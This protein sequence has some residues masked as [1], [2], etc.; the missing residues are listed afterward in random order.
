MVMRD[1]PC[2]ERLL[3][4][5]ALIVH[6]PPFPEKRAAIERCA[7]EIEEMVRSGGLTGVQGVALLDILTG[8]D[9]RSRR[10]APLRS[11]GPDSGTSRGPT[12]IGLRPSPS[13]RGAA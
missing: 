2:Y 12:P 13:G 11:G 6:H 8:D 10:V 5:V 1:F 7:G 4:A 9:P 3:R